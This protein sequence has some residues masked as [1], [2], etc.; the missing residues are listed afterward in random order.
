MLKGYKYKELY[1]FDSVLGQGGMGEVWK[2]KRLEVG[3]HAAV[4]ILKHNIFEN[5][6]KARELLKNEAKS[7]ASLNHPNICKLFEFRDDEEMS[8]LCMEL[9]EGMTLQELIKTAQI[10]GK[11]LSST[12]I[13]SVIDEILLAL[14]YTHNSPEGKILHRDIKPA[15][16]FITKYGEVKVLD[17][18]ISKSVE[19]ANT[20]SATSKVF[21]S[22]EYTS[23]DLWV[24]GV[25]NTIA[26]DERND[27]YSLGLIFFELFTLQKA[28]QGEGIR[29]LENLSKGNVEN[30][31]D[32]RD[33][34]KDIIKLY[35]KWTH[36][37]K[38]KRFQSAKEALEKLKGLGRT[39]QISKKEIE[40]TYGQIVSLI[41]VLPADTLIE[42]KPK[43]LPSKRKN[44]WVYGAVASVSLIM[45]IIS[46]FVI[47]RA[48]VINDNVGNGLLLLS[49]NYSY[50]FKMPDKKG[51]LGL[52]EITNSTLDLKGGTCN[53]F[54]GVSYCNKTYKYDNYADENFKNPYITVS[55]SKQN[56]QIKTISFNPVGIKLT[57]NF[58]S[59]NQTLFEKFERKEDEDVG[60]ISKEI[61]VGQSERIELIK[62]I[63]PSSSNDEILHAM[64][65]VNPK[66]KDDDRRNKFVGAFK[67]PVKEKEPEQI[68]YSTLEDIFSNV[69]NP[70]YE[71]RLPF[72][73][74]TL[75]AGPHKN[76]PFDEIKLNCKYD[77][78][79]KN[80]CSYHK[81]DG[82]N[83][84][85]LKIVKFLQGIERVGLRINGEDFVEKFIHKNQGVF[86]KSTASKFNNINGLLDAKWKDDLY[87]LWI[88]GN[89]DFNTKKPTRFK[90][91]LT[92]DDFK[93]Y[94]KRYY[95][96][97]K[98]KAE[99]NFKATVIDNTLMKKGIGELGKLC[100]SGSGD[101]CFVAA[102]KEMNRGSI[103][104]AQ[105]LYEVACNNGL[106][107]G[108]YE[109]GNIHY[110]NNRMNDALPWLEKACNKN[111]PDSCN[112]W[113]RILITYK[114]K[115]EDGLKAVTKACEYGNLDGCQ[116][117][118]E[119]AMQFVTY[120]FD[121]QN[122]CDYGKYEGC[123]QFGKLL[124]MV[125]KYERAKH[126]LNKTCKAG[127]QQ[128]C[129]E[130]ARVPASEK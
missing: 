46:F 60:P 81:K 34:D 122:T 96:D 105:K 35:S 14:D 39:E 38:N 5:E 16:I 79:G 68:V 67:A 77:Y 8:F 104:T 51:Q 42:N 114:G 98:R 93:K 23:P 11:E 7:I 36:K 121:A 6:E 44:K 59:L 83:E 95:F 72:V 66:N 49:S 45:G 116:K 111:H 73:D 87:E 124:S 32:Y 19:E 58:L 26:Y 70:T 82:D 109:V 123:V 76:Y 129:I 89:G 3:G 107:E 22:Q 53:D 125:K 65:S 40:C 99:L 52:G 85:D 4:K 62:A 43:K 120:L 56:N 112:K 97:S 61:W 50:S 41:N 18:G 64:I 130:Y 25:Y 110:I 29:L 21:F 91:S 13:F 12:F 117:E 78:S 108:C 54:Q 106:T 69:K 47:R 118:Y 84:L 1:E 86:N 24:N 55:F 88:T 100:T 10:H 80:L 103:Y 119:I 127:F 74:I 48:P 126:V 15:N 57:K 17:F 101:A 115:T 28:Y 71:F 2:V 128:A 9:L 37:N 90:L 92:I 102:K 75:G 63:N 20:K 31:E 113:G 27:L 33:V 30:L 94:Q